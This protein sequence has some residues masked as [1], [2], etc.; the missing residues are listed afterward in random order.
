MIY[1]VGAILAGFIGGALM[2][3]AVLD[4]IEQCR[5]TP[6]AHDSMCS[7]HPHLPPP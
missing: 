2:V 4:F 3:L 6:A 5:A 7:S 1:L